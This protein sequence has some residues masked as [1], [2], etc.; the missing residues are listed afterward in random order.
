MIMAHFLPLVLAC[1]LL[2]LGI[3]HS[4]IGPMGGS[5][6]AHDVGVR[7]RQSARASTD[8]SPPRL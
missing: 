3:G 2:V 8:A 4:E 7:M 5:R 6:Q 1:L